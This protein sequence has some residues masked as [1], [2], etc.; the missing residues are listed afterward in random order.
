MKF[1]IIAAAAAAAASCAPERLSCDRM[2]SDATAWAQ[3][4]VG[5][6]FKLRDS[7]KF[8]FA[9]GR[10]VEATPCRWRIA[11]TGTAENSLGGRN[12]FKWQADAV[13]APDALDNARPRIE[14]VIID[15][16]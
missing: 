1:V 11:G 6:K 12:A 5:K 7:V 3:V 2:E 14:N 16:S 15:E 8:G 4:E 9:A 10:I 13:Y